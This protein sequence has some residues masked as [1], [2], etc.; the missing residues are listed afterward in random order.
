MRKI[1]VVLLVAVSLVISIPILSFAQAYPS[2]PIHLTVTFPPGGSL[3]PSTRALVEGAKKFTN[4]PI[5][6]ENKAGGGGTV[7]LAEAAHQAPDGYH[8]VSYVVSAMTRMPHLRP[9]PYKLEDFVPVMQFAQ[10]PS[11]VAVQADSPWKTFKDLVEY[12]RKNPKKIRY[13]TQGASTPQE[14]SM[15]LIGRKEGISWIHV[16][17]KG[18][19]P[20]IAALLGRNVECTCVSTDFIPHVKAGTL[21]ALAILDQQRLED[22]PDIPTF[23]E[24]GYDFLNEYITDV[25]FFIAAPKGTPLSA[26]EKFDEILHKAMKEPQFVQTLKNMQLTPF[27]RGH[28]MLPAYF[29]RMYDDFGKVVKDLDL[30][31]EK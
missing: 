2:K 4:Q 8:F 24:L 21:R 16:P 18:T 28:K 29:K 5:I 6:I 23:K 22:F 17:Y 31:V 13:S 3:D 15:E 7:G 25:G 26:V 30:K 14:V 11:G 10:V 12:A 20:A 1:L 27:Y 19:A 9:L